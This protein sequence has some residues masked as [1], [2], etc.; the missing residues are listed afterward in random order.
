LN[1]LATTTQIPVGVDRI[2]FTRS[3]RE[4][5]WR[6]ASSGRFRARHSVERVATVFMMFSAPVAILTTLGIVASLAAGRVMRH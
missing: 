5:H 3:N 4:A 2:D 1:R 6:F